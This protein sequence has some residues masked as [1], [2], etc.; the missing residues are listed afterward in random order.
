MQPL[1]KQL[2]HLVELYIQALGM[3][4]CPTTLV[5][6]TSGERYVFIVSDPGIIPSN[7]IFS[8]LYLTYRGK[9]KDAR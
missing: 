3:V 2:K 5:V 9:F 4:H 8:R 1:A 6:V 7:I